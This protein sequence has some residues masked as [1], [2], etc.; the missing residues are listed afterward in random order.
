MNSCLLIPNLLLDLY[1]VHI[2]LE[3]NELL[4][5]KH[6]LP[7]LVTPHILVRIIATGEGHVWWSS[8]LTKELAAVSATR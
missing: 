6:L 1:L 3:I 5:D 8:I 2:A 4:G 7:S